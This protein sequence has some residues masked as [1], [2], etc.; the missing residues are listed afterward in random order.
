MLTKNDLNQISNLF[1]NS[2]K[3]LEDK[4]D[5]LKRNLVLL[6]SRVDGLG[7]SVAILERSVKTNTGAIVDIEST[8]KFYG[9]MYELNKDDINK[10]AARTNTIENRVGVETKPELK[11]RGI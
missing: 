9:D 6:T 11:V 2:L 4:I 7:N 3:R 8:I 10:L 1:G 5:R